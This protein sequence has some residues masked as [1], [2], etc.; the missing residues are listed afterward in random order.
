MAK[1]VLGIH[2]AIFHPSKFLMINHDKSFHIGQKKWQKMFLEF[3]WKFFIPA[4]RS[5]ISLRISSVSTDLPFTCIAPRI[6]LKRSKLKHPN[7]CTGP[8]S[9]TR[10][11]KWQW[12]CIF[13]VTTFSPYSFSNLSPNL[14]NSRSALIMS[15]LNRT[16]V[17]RYWRARTNVCQHLK[18]VSGN[19]SFKQ[20][21]E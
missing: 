13:G 18:W 5:A 15:V 16:G 19:R 3:T 20:N 14:T 11:F 7:A 17:Q 9:M 21:M 10:S 4:N 6:P 12:K 8:Q 1:N 2:L